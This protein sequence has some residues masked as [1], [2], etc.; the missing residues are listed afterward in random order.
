MIRFRLYI[1]GRNV[2]E[3]ICNFHYIISKSVWFQFNPIIGVDYSDPLFYVMSAKV[4]H[5]KDTIF[6]PL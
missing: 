1:F 4:L 3:M 6:P 2:T 5:Y